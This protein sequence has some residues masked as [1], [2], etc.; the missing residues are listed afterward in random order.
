MKAVISSITKISL[1]EL[2]RLDPIDVMIEDL[3]PEKGRI[4]I[5]CYTQAWTAYW[6]A[7]GDRSISQFFRNCDEHYLAKNLAVGLSPDI[8]DGEAFIAAAQREIRKLR[9]AGDFTKSKARE[10]LDELSCLNGLTTVNEVWSHA[11]ILVPIFGDEWWYSMPSRPNPEYEYLCS[12]IKAVQE[13]LAL[14]E[15]RP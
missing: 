9:R 6:G 4:N 5:R 2:D 15:V 7:M 11:S 1:T 14:A 8:S 10:L 13:G 3:A 12:I